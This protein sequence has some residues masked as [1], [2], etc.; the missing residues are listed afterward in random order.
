MNITQSTLLYFTQMFNKN[1]VKHSMVLFS[2]FKLGIYMGI[3][4]V[5]F[6]LGNMDISMQRMDLTGF[7]LPLTDHCYCPCYQH[8]LTGASC[9]PELPSNAVIHSDAMIL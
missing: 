6:T 2:N 9:S 8:N 4:P 3:N 5:L 1:I 7:Y